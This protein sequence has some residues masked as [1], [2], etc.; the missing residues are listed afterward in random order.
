MN[1]KVFSLKYEKREQWAFEQVSNLL[2]CAEF[3]NRIG[4]FRF[5]TQTGLKTEKM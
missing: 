3:G 4:L 5:K 1:W 2:F